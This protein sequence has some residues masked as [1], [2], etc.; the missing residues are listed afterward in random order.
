MGSVIKGYGYRLVDNR[1]FEIPLPLRCVLMKEDNPVAE[2]EVAEDENVSVRILTKHKEDMLTPV[3]RSLDISDVYYFF[4]TRVFQDKTPFTFSELRL[5]GMERYN[6]YEIIRK[7]RGVTPYD[8]YWIRFSGDESDY[9]RAKA[10][11]TE[12][13]ANA[14]GSASYAEPTT[15]TESSVPKSDASVNEILSQHKVDIAAKFAEENTQEQ[16]KQVEKPAPK[17]KEEPANTMSA[18]EIEAL[19]LKS[20]LTDSVLDSVAA[21][22]KEDYKPAPESA[23]SGGKM[24]QEDIEKML[25]GV[26]EPE[27]EIEPVEET[28]PE[29]VS[30]GGKMSQ[31]DIEKMLAGVSEPEPETESEPVEETAPES[32]PSG[33]KMSQED[34]EK[35]L[36]G[37]SEPETEIEPVEETVPESAPSG[38]KMSQEDIEKML[39]GI[40]EPEPTPEPEPIEETAPEPVSSGGKMSQEDIEKMLA[41]ISEPEPTPEPEPV[42]ETA[43]EPVSSGGKMSQEDIEKMLAGISEPEPTPE[44]EPIEDTKPESAPSGGKMSQADIEALLSGMANDAT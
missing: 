24:S 5:L 33:G 18:D 23:P 42:E 27:T 31:E 4:S 26:S 12:L 44:P 32:A 38:G 37:V 25:A 14:A 30:S 19:L 40:S 21:M 16:V 17:K 36:A 7:T 39:A 2:Y 34:I 10:Q 28:V 41:G 15:K 3:Y 1:S 6:V 9:E 8:D 11:W 22:P 13:M 35:M 20:G 29:P 43:P